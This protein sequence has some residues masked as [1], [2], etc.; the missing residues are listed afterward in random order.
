[1]T[2][3]ASR[4]CPYFC[5]LT[6]NFSLRFLLRRLFVVMIFVNRV[7][8][9]R[10]LQLHGN[11]H[12]RLVHLVV[13]SK[14]LETLRQHLHL[15]RSVRNSVHTRVPV[16]SRLQF[17]FFLA[18]RTLAINR[19]HHHLRILHRLP[20]AVA[21][22][23]KPHRRSGPLIVLS[24][25]QMTN[26]RQTRQPRHKN[27]N[28]HPITNS[29][30]HSTLDPRILLLQFDFLLLTYPLPYCGFCSGGLGWSGAFGSSGF[31]SFSCTTYVEYCPLG[32]FNRTVICVSGC[33]IS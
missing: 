20:V 11:F 32:R 1:S 18:R 30:S 33:L 25:S 12:L 5:N 10:T 6:S 9:R 17:H 29:K 3:A 2:P 24:P 21:H 27:C 22:H 7:L 23:H 14:C 26:A 8:P 15:D 31:F 28:D 19:M 16:G 4:Q 13:F